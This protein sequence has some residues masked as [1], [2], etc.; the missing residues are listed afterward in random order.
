MSTINIEAALLPP[1][2]GDHTN[3]A[4]ALNDGAYAKAPWPSAHRDIRNSDY[5]P[6][7]SPNSIITLEGV[8]FFM[9][10]T[11]DA[12]GNVSVTSAGRPVPSALFR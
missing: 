12:S 7:P 3:R 10:L 8:N 5:V 2:S 11:V 4:D 1:G 9:G 6:Y